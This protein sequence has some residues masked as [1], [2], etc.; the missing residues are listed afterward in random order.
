MAVILYYKSCYGFF[1]GNSSTQIHNLD[2]NRT[3]SCEYPRSYWY[4][5][6]RFCRY[7]KNV[8]AAL[9]SPESLIKQ[10]FASDYWNRWWP[11]SSNLFNVGLLNWD[12]ITPMCRATYP[13]FIHF[14]IILSSFP[15]SILYWTISSSSKLLMVIRSS[16]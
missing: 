13:L 3:V 5:Y 4:L 10:I 6:A 16:K 12:I 1:W 7:I 14:T 8:L 11:M 9:K 15:S 2:S